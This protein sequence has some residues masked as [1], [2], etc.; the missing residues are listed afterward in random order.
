MSKTRNIPWEIIATGD[1]GWERWQSVNG[2]PAKLIAS[3]PAGAEFSFSKSALPAGAAAGASLG[4]AS[5]VVRLR[6]LA[7]GC[8]PDSH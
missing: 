1:T 7:A 4:H 8:A 6:R 5:L 2:Q 3:H